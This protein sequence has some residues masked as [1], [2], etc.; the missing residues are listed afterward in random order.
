M[1]ESFRSR[2]TLMI[3]AICAITAWNVI[4]LNASK[5]P[6]NNFRLCLGSRCLFQAMR[7]R[8]RL[9]CINFLRYI[10]IAGAATHC[11]ASIRRL[12]V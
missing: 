8:L 1:A 4:V 6:Y 2:V 3:I 12:A 5:R 11:A 7:Y 10:I 9:A